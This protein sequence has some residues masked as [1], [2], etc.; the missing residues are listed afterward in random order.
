MNIDS[1][2]ADERLRPVHN[3]AAATSGSMLYIDPEA[4][5]WM[6]ERLPAQ[7]NE[8]I[9]AT[10]GI[11]QNTWVKIRDGLPIRRSVGERLLARLNSQRN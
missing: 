3:G 2:G 9:T 4:V 8:A 10:F 7:T 1:T 5:A 6:R 11:S